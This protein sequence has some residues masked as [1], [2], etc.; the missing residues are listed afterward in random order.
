MLIDISKSSSSGLH[1]RLLA[2]LLQS[3]WSEPESTSQ[4]SQS[5]K[6][7]L[8]PRLITYAYGSSQKPALYTSA[9]KVYF[10]RLFILSIIVKEQIPI[11]SSP[12]EACKMPKLWSSPLNGRDS[13]KSTKIGFK[14][15]LSSLF[16]F[17]LTSLWSL[18]A[19]P[20]QYFDVALFENGRI[21]L[22]DYR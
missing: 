14:V 19:D 13:E 9:F 1:L 7:K 6:L 20:Q 11:R 16:Y 10:V 8:K 2:N 21:L 17:L 4:H 15:Y 3:P 22:R 12:S 18:S 5:L